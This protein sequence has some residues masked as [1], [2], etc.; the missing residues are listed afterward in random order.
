MDRYQI[1]TAHR[2]HKVVGMEPNGR[3]RLVNTWRT[4]EA[5]IAHRKALRAMIERADRHSHPS[6]KDWR[7]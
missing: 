6:E 2:A 7:G 1:I 4:E 5:A 3:T